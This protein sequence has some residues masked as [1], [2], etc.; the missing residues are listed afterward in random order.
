MDCLVLALQA[1]RW[2][3]SWYK[4]PIHSTGDGNRVLASIIS[5]AVVP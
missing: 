5:D 2:G 3:T 1:K 4:D